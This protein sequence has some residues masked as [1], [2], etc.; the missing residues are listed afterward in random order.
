MPQP[1]GLLDYCSH[2]YILGVAQSGK[3]TL[4]RARVASARRAV[5]FD[6]PGDSYQDEGELIEAS[7]LLAHPELLRGTVVRWVVVPGEDVAADFRATVAACRAAKQHGG[8][9]L[10][11]DEL[12]NY[13]KECADVLA[14]LHC[15]GHH[16]GVA[17]VLVSQFAVDVPK[18]CRRSATRVTSL[19]QT[20]ED[21]LEALAEPP[22]G[23]DF[24]E[25]VRSW[26][27]G[28]P[29]AVWSLPTLYQPR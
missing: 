20:N 2:E 9:V 4:A 16:D 15:N 13:S 24:A 7:D 12:V 28:D 29:P 25:R 17:S 23:P 19:L 3:S 6:P 11:G 5:F 10:V 26:R 22:L 21:D 8:L 14:R 18:T 1:F 27:P